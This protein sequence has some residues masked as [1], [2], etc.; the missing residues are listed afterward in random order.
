MLQYPGSSE[1]SSV[2]KDLDDAFRT[3]KT[4]AGE[5]R[6][7]QIRQLW[8]MMEEQEVVLQEALRLDEGKPKFEAQLFEMGLVKNDCLHALAHLDEWMEP[9]TVDVPFPFSNFEP[10]TLRQPRGVALIISPWNFP[11]NLT[12]L[13]LLGAITGGCCAVLKPSEHT[14][15][16]AQALADLL[17]RYL[18]PECFRIV[19]GD[20]NTTQELLKHRFDTILFTGSRQNGIKVMQAAAKHLTPVTL[21]LGGKSPIIISSKANLPI[22][23]KRLAWGRFWNE[24]QICMVPEYALVQET[25]SESFLDALKKVAHS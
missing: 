24:G 16:V 22:A 17:P 20:G 25:V 12:M 15:H 14:P 13:P 4:R 3:G 9:E 7:T 8:T 10:R 21:E 5:W 1:I 19:N 18:D 23:A 2:L 6:K 11:V